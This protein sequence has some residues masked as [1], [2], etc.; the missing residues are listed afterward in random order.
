METEFLDML[1]KLNFKAAIKELL[2]MH[3]RDVYDFL[4]DRGAD[5]YDKVGALTSDGLFYY[6]LAHIRVFG[7]CVLLDYFSDSDI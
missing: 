6:A 4:C 5:P 1:E 2:C 7:P 3:P